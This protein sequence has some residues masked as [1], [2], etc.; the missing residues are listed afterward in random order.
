[1]LFSQSCFSI[2]LLFCIRDPPIPDNKTSHWQGLH[3]NGPCLILII[4]PSLAKPSH[5]WILASVKTIFAVSQIIKHMTQAGKP[6]PLELLEQH[7][8]VWLICLAVLI[9]LKSITTKLFQGGWEIFMFD[10]LFQTWNQYYISFRVS[11]KLCQLLG[12]QQT[13]LKFLEH[14]LFSFVENYLICYSLVIWSDLLRIE[15][16]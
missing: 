15:I 16:I 14:M 6:P 11:G 12:A 7:K 13:W 9:P 2:C 3:I 4:F 5:L 8:S 1:M 10:I